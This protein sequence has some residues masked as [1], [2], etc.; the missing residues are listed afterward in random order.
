MLEQPLAAELHAE[1][2]NC[3]H[4]MSPYNDVE[5]WKQACRGGH[6]PPEV[7]R[8]KSDPG[9]AATGR[10]YMDFSAAFPQG[11]AFYILIQRN[12]NIEL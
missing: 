6:W 10:P 8:R 11:K 9:R 2:A 7:P 4:E 1:I 12:D 5:N 3:N